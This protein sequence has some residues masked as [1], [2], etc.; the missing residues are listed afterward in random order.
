MENKIVVYTSSGCSYC[1]QV[2]EILTEEQVEFDERNISENLDYFKEW[3]AKDVLG[4]PATFLG[5]E[6]V[7]GVEKLKLVKLAE[8]VKQH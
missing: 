5:E 8:K 4:T 7:L 2:L 6:L 3:K 1:D